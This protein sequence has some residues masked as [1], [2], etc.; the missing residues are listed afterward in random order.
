ML[1]PAY[2]VS[3]LLTTA[4]AAQ[5]MQR[6]SARDYVAT[7]R[8]QLRDQP[9]T[10]VWDGPVP[11]NVIGR[12]LRGG[13][14]CPPGCSRS[15][16]SRPRYDEP[17][18][19]LRMFDGLGLLRPVDILPEARSVRSR[20]PACGYGV[21]AGGAR[22]VPLDRVA[23]AG[24]QVI[25]IGYYAA[26]SLPGTVTADLTVT[27]VVFQQGVH[28]VF[29][30]VQGPVAQLNVGLDAAEPGAGICATDVVV[31]QPWPKPGS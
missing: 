3:C 27:R 13:R 16:R 24:R 5:H 11:E 7:A 1:L 14:E 15:R 21:Q 22:P 9:G 23:G 25:R 30:V 18:G 28:Y 4:L 12:R 20:T 17:T 6:I 31:G 8:A 29:V 19:D 26:R 2:L 10:V